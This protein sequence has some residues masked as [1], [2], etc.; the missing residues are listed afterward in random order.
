MKNLIF[1][2]ALV[3]GFGFTAISQV[4]VPSNVKDGFAKKF[5]TATK[6][7][8]EKE[9][10]TEYEATFKMDGKSISANF[11]IQGNW[12]ETEWE[13]RIKELPE[14]V[15]TAVTDKYPGFEI[16]VAEYCETPDFTGYE[17][18]IEKSEGKEEVEKE[19][20]VSKDG[21]SIKE[22]TEETDEE[23]DE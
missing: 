18:E 1:L 5:P 3:L 14:A 16:D 6:V 11:D 4:E 23:S 21:K 9:N 15:V 20:Q 12:M 17:M 10:D 2:I 13:V 7:K 19:I 8:W 22:L